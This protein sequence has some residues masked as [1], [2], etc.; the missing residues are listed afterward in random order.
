MTTN[1]KRRAKNTKGDVKMVTTTTRPQAAARGGVPQGNVESIVRSV[2][3]ALKRD[4]NAGE[5][6]AVKF[7]RAFGKE[8][9]RANIQSDE[10]IRERIT[11]A[12]AKRIMGLRESL[13]M[14]QSEFARRTGMVQSYV[15]HIERGTKEPSLT[16]LA[17]VAAA[18]GL[19]LSELVSVC[20]E[21]A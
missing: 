3:E 20:D 2:V 16:V 8:A 13:N 17:R 4:P 7:G 11:K 10:M 6:L 5:E 14:N 12:L 19:K 9:G 1:G 15:W 21:A 18:L